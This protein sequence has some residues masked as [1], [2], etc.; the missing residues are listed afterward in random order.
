MVASTVVSGGSPPA[1]RIIAGSVVTSSS[2]TMR[3]LVS[4]TYARSTASR[5]P[6][7]AER[8]AGTSIGSG[9]DGTVG[10]R[11]DP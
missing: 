5:R 2:S 3:G 10:R 1:A 11:A 7:R 8:S 6:R 4:A 9:A